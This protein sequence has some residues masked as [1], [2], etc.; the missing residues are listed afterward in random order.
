M[1][2]AKRLRKRRSNDMAINLNIEGVKR[3]DLFF[4]PLTAVIATPEENTRWD[5]P[6]RDKL[7]ELKESLRVNGQLVPAEVILT[8][9]KTKASVHSGNQRLAMLRELEAE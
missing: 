7:D 8:P 6:S 1:S 9:D 3:G 4:L 5:A 2:G